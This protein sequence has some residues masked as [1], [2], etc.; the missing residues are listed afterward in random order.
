MLAGDYNV[1][2]GAADADNPT[3]WMGD[4]LFQPETRA[5][6]GRSESRAHR[7]HPRPIARAATR[8]GTIRPAPGS[9]TTASAS[10][11]SSLAGGRRPPGRRGHPQARARLGQAL[12][13]R[14]GMARFGDRGAARR[15]GQVPCWQSNRKFTTRGQILVSGSQ[16]SASTAMLPFKRTERI[17]RATASEPK[18]PQDGA[19]EPFKHQAVQNPSVQSQTVQVAASAKQSIFWSPISAS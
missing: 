6:A 11:T 4:A 18:A 13:P 17:D 16:G 12:R 7:R 5:A 9:G 10:T 8:S 1:I 3:S 14:A 2:P 19:D 15:V